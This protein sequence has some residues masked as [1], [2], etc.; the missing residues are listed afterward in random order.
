MTVKYYAILT[1]QGAA[2]LANA[3]MLGSKLNLTQMAVGDAN[4]V[5]PTPDPAQTKLINQKRIAPLN[6]LSVDPNN[7]SQIIAEQIIPENE[8][9]FW[10]REIGLYDDEGV[11]IAVANCPETYKPQLQEGSGR[12]QT[13][14]MI[15]VVTNTEAITLKIDP[16]VVL[17]TRKYVDD[18]I[19]EHEQSRRHPDAS[20]TVKGFTQLSSAINSESETLAATPKAVKAAYDLANE[21]YT[22]Q[23][24][25]T[26][27]KGIVQLSSATNSTS[28]TLAATPKAVKAV[29]DETN[30]K[31]PLNSPALTGTPTTPTAPQGTNS[32][33]IASTAFVMAAIA[34][35]V[36]S[37]PDAL[38][39]L[40]EL[41]AA[42]GNDPNFATTM[43][44]A[45]A[46]KQP[47]DAT[48]TALAELATSAD[49]L[50]YFTG[51]DRA[52]LTALTSVGRAIL[53]KTSTQGVLDY[54]GLSDVLHKGNFGVGDRLQGSAAGGS[55]VGGFMYEPYQAN[56]LYPL[57]VALMQA[58]GPT[59]T[60]WSQLAVSYGGA[61]RAFLGR[62]TY[63]GNPEI[64]EL[65]HDQ[66]KPSASDVGAQPVDATLTGLS[67]KDAAGLRTYM[68]LGTASTKN[69]GVG[70][71]QIP[72]MSSF[73][74]GNS[75][76][77]F[78][79]KFPNGMVVMGGYAPSITGG[80]SGNAVFFPIPFPNVCSCVIPA[81]ANSGL[82]GT[83]PVSF[84]VNV[85]NQSR[86]SV[87]TTNTASTMTIFWLAFGS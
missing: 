12:T 85:D 49:K 37:S 59:A 52:A 70:S 13:I 29:M 40:N 83:G 47:K 65:Y 23:N 42:L 5:L 74:A 11:L 1:N 16:S 78:W 15:L 25:T 46:G 41:A 51:A 19:S 71:G 76:T 68:G 58:A 3:T 45:L 31:A 7:Q 53:G 73:T 39:T 82:Y 18:K 34:A 36:D 56:N 14:R 32:T 67:G 62:Q 64:S 35:L 55:H 10:I 60:E 61:F 72:D 22:A 75:S 28:E 26:T 66:R 79:Y 17:A 69:V 4:G 6:L 43:T 63:N 8:G 33:Q 9:G 20:L 80:S 84:N 30:K 50:P 24:A 21:K 44:N 38:N 54:L 27:Q 2:R 77:A 48:L 87:Y 57:S 86:F 81:L